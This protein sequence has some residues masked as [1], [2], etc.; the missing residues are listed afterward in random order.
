MKAIES[1]Y[2]WAEA[3]NIEVIFL[4]FALE[5]DKQNSDIFTTR[6][7]FEWC[8]RITVYVGVTL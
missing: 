5:L 7:G 3:R 1:L 4:S 8:R 6:K 2:I